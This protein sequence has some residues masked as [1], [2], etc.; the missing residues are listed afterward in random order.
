MKGTRSSKVTGKA[1]GAGLNTTTGGIATET[2]IPGVFAIE[3]VTEIET[4]T[5]TVTATEA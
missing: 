3:I 2:V 4:A 5:V 1:I